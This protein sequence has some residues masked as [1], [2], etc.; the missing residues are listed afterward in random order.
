MVGGIFHV[1]PGGN[2]TV[3]NITIRKGNVRDIGGGFYNNF[4]LKKNFR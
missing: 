2:L 3:E 1:L 4:G